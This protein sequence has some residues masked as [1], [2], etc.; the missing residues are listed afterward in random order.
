MGRLLHHDHP[1]A[2]FRRGYRLRPEVIA[3]VRQVLDGRLEPDE[4]PGRQV[5]ESGRR[6][7]IGK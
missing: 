5:V 2:G 3:D 1:L 4:I 6:Y 7:R